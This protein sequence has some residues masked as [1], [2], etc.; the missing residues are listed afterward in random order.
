MPIDKKKLT[1]E[2]LKKASQC[3]T[4]EE[5]IAL[6]K[7]EGFEITKAEAEAYLTE[8]ENIELDKA[9]LENV[10]GGGKHNTE[11]SGKINAKLYG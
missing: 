7:A 1:K 6:A 5:L 2:M 8:L 9:E 4:A 3:K 11:M 10:A